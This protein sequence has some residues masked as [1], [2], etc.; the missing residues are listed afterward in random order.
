MAHGPH[1]WRSEDGPSGQTKI[2]SFDELAPMKLDATGEFLTAVYEAGNRQ[3]LPEEK[4]KAQALLARVRDRLETLTAGTNWYYDVR[5]DGK[6]EMVAIVEGGL[7]TTN[8]HTYGHEAGGSL[9]GYLSDEFFAA[10]RKILGDGANTHIKN[11][12]IDLSGTDDG[13]EQLVKKG[14]LPFDKGASRVHVLFDDFDKAEKDVQAVID[15]I[16]NKSDGV[17]NYARDKLLSQ[18]GVRNFTPPGTRWQGV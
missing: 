9:V 13:F 5:K 16:N 8:G 12:V 3:K 18:K 14:R 17:G 6:L 1:G 15:H 10:Q 4:S 2:Y 7:N 11:E